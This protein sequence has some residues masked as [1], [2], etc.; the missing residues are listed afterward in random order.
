MGDF[1]TTVPTN[2]AAGAKYRG[3][4]ATIFSD[5][6]VAQTAAWSAWSPTLTNLTLGSGS[7]IANY[8][9]I[10]KT[11]DFLWKWTYGAGSAVGTNPTFTLPV[12][13]SG[14][15]ASGNT[16]MFVNAT[17][18]DFGTTSYIAEARIVTASVTLVTRSAISTLSSITSTAPFT[19]TTSDGMAVWGTIY[20][21]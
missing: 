6:A 12:T 4:D 13:P 10:G 2:V 1:T 7:Q 18:W 11:V 20:T 8:R 14:D 9:R 5:L 19:W 15:W 16:A 21:A 3:F 17:L